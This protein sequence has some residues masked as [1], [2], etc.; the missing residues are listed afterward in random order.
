MKT[1]NLLKELKSYFVKR[2]DVVMAFLFGSYST[3]RVHKESDIDIAIYIKPKGGVEIEAITNY[4]CENDIWA[5]VEKIAK[6]E[7]DLLILNRAS[8]SVCDVAVRTGIPIIIKNRRI[9]LRYLLAVSDLAEEF[10]SY[11]FDVW[12]LRNATTGR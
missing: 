1:D 7:V 5:D 12:R 2:E 8:S 3:G 10:R 9:Y 6:R 11:I 4:K